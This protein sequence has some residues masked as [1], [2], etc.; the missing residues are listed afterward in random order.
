MSTLVGRSRELSALPGPAG[1][2]SRGGAALLMVGEAG[3]GKSALLQQAAA[4]ASEHGSRVLHLGPAGPS[5]APAPFDALQRLLA[6]LAADAVTLTQAHRAAL[7]VALRAR[8]GSTPSRSLL[9][10]AV[11]ALL[12]ATEQPVLALVDD[13]QEFDPASAEVLGY[14]ARRVAGTNASVV[15]ATRPDAGAA[16][17][18][19]DV[20]RLRVGPLHADDAR[21]LLGRHHPALSHPVRER[22]LREARGNPLALLELP[23]SLSVPQQRGQ[24]ALP[25][26][27]TVTGIVTDVFGARLAALPAPTREALLLLAL[28]GTGSLDV[29][30]AA[31][32][33]G[34]LAL[35]PAERAGLVKV[36]EELGR[37]HFRHPLLQPTVVTL[38]DDRSRRRAHQR[39]AEVLHHVPARRA[40]H[41]AE[42]TSG[43]DEHVAA[44]LE[45]EARRRLRRGDPA[46][47]AA[48]LLRAAAL[49]EARGERARR[50]VH[51]ALL[52]ADATGDLRGAGELLAEAARA[53]PALTR[54]LPATLV[55]STMLLNGEGEAAT[56]HRLLSEAI[57]SYP[58]RDPDDALLEEALHALLLMSWF[59]GR[60]EHWHP[61]RRVLQ[62]LGPGAP[63]LLDLVHRAFADPAGQ[64]HGAIVDLERMVQAAATERD[65]VTVL[66]VA[67]ACAYV[68]RLG[69]VRPALRRVLA[70][71]REN[72]A[73]VLALH[74]LVSC[75]IDAWHSGE[76]DEALALAEEGVQLCEEHGYDRYAVMLGGYLGHLVG[77][78]RGDLDDA[79]DAAQ[80][81]A[82][83][84]AG[85][86]AGTATQF[87]EHLRCLAAIATGDYET[88]FAH[89][90]AVSAPGELAPYHPQALWL[91]L[92]LVESAVRTGRHDAAARHVEVMAKRRLAELSPRLEMVTAGCAA[93]LATG[94][95]ARAEATRWFDRAL[96][97]PGGRRWPFDRARIQL[98]Y[99]EHLR[100]T[101]RVPAARDELSAALDGF[102]MLG[103]A[104]WAGRASEQ[105]RAAGVIGP[106]R[107]RVQRP[108][109]ERERDVAALAARGL[110]NR[111]IGDRL[112]LSP[113]S[114]GSVLYR[115]FPKLGITS[116]AAL[117]AALAQ[118][119]GPDAG[120][121][122]RDG[123]AS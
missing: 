83:W 14:V 96:A 95:D 38:A 81:L 121:A 55:A 13:L 54:S 25:R 16:F 1:G 86:G 44:L 73:V 113:R 97:V 7:D 31:D 91:L 66:R 85:R 32:G 33:D 45:D 82:V 3:I 65:P 4:V 105:L 12:T 69:Q 59:A 98:A 34:L 42:A 57:E 53:E 61:F 79:E 94:A 122:P 23:R 2:P 29:L 8:P 20:G 80:E 28:D 26:P 11:L 74:A 68:D 64:A 51:A 77:I 70:D 93:L 30:Q 76:W 52:D 115:V 9:G 49:S 92:E 41:L 19:V 40:W 78:A 39:L 89:A 112:F 67:L 100:R 118:P 71:A 62:E 104:P 108:L 110:T 123:S 114:V 87:A 107:A 84:A 27:I 75:T 116:R 56:A 17:D 63:A 46:G 90:C 111:E 88:A 117:S 60:P 72:G 103:A 36:E 43:T 101:G 15:V 48:H 47:A 109:T 120:Q 24:A 102:R 106:V 35:A 6:P 18:R 119:P 99:G 50:Q 10:V 58:G 5:A 21:A 22:V 37:W